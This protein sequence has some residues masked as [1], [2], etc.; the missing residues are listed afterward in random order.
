VRPGW[1]F[2]T[3]RVFLSAFEVPMKPML[4]IL[5]I[6]LCAAAT[7]QAAETRLSNGIIVSDAFTGSLAPYVLEGCSPEMTD[8]QFASYANRLNKGEL[9]LAKERYAKYLVDRGDLKY[10]DVYSST[11]NTDTQFGGGH[12]MGGMGGAGGYL[13]YGVNGFGSG[14]GVTLNPGGNGYGQGFQGNNGASFEGNRMSE[15]EKFTSRKFRHIYPDLNDN[16]G[17]PVTIIN[18]YCADYWRKQAAK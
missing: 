9:Y 2:S 1:Y 5:T 10:E 6:V 4:L 7:V 15:L 17:G 16:G 12:G 14:Y 8:E 3:S 11:R 13:G 18:P